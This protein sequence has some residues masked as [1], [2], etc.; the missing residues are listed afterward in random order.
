ADCRD[1]KG[2]AHYTFGDRRRKDLESYMARL[3]TAFRS[4]AAMLDERSVVVQLVAFSKPDLQLQ[5][6]LDVMSEVGLSETDPTGVGGT[7]ERV[8]RVVPNRKWYARVKADTLPERHEVLLM[9]RKR[10][11]NRTD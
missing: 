2:S 4:I 1:G 9:H 3:R 6:Y 10:M 11:R 5:P 7:C 8:W